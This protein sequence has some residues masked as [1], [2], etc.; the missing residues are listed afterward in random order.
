M[1]S[2]LSCD[3][4]LLSHFHPQC[5]DFSTLRTFSHTNSRPSVIL[6]HIRKALR[7]FLRRLQLCAP[8]DFFRF[9]NRSF[10]SP[11]FHFKYESSKSFECV[12]HCRHLS[13]I[14]SHY[15]T[16]LTTTERMAKPN[17]FI[18]KAHVFGSATEEIRFSRPMLNG[19]AIFERRV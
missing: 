5:Y 11:H 14:R 4:S 1:S 2:Y 12:P 3:F 15:E 7:N 10:M 18:R 9:K 8:K 13:V 16:L 19:Y 6:R 17:A